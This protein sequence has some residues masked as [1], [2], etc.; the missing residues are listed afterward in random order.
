M[1]HAD[2]CYFHL[3]LTWLDWSRSR[4]FWSRSHNRFLV[5]VSV[6]I[7]VSHSLVSVLALV[8]LCSVSLTSLDCMQC[9]AR[10]SHKKA[11]CLSI[12]LSNVCIV[13]KRNTTWKTIHPSFLTR[14]V[15]GDD[16][17]YLKF[18]VNGAKTPIFNRYSLVAPHP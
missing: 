14:M 9:N 10:Y 11:I 4:S 12:C 13:T 15:D 3:Q 7:L 16:P 1:K 18:W 5:W 8:S 2:S 6:S 17:L